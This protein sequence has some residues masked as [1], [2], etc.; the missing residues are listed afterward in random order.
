MK[1]GLHKNLLL[2]GGALLILTA[3]AAAEKRGAL[4]TYI[5]PDGGYW[6]DVANWDNGIPN[7][8]FDA[9]IDADPGFDIDVLLNSNPVV[10]NLTIDAG[11]TLTIFN[12]RILRLHSYDG[13][14][15]LSNAGSIFLDSTASYTYL[16]FHP[17]NANDVFA[18]TGGGEIVGTGNGPNQLAEAYNQAILH[19]YDNT[20]RGSS[21]NICANGL[22]FI[23]DGLVVSDSGGIIL[24]DPPDGFHYG[25]TNGGTIR[26][27]GG[28]MDLGYGHFGNDGGVIEALNGSLVRLANGAHIHGG[29]IR[30]IDGGE[31][32]STTGASYL[33]LATGFTPT[34]EGTLRVEN[35]RTLRTY[36]PGEV[37]NT[38]SII[39]DSTGSY[40]YLQVHPE[41]A[42]DVVTLTGAGEI[43][44]IAGGPNQIAEAYNQ[45]I[46]RAS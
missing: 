9:R 40:T 27:D 20:F 21:I 35:N 2:G 23:N 24:I 8:N 19:N 25:C 39:L 38:G 37:H 32:R 41:N 13:T 42:N 43:V 11:D 6:N 33:N 36:G 4:T 5:G 22:E 26:A 18:L 3:G 12:N 46:G 29:M 28:D 16:Q 7:G 31:V 10:H 45:E 15:V 30:G 34:I 44:G 14:S 17:V 1:T